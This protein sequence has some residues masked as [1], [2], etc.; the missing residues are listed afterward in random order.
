MVSGVAPGRGGHAAVADVEVDAVAAGLA[1]ADRDPHTPLEP[2]GHEQRQ[3]TMP[4]PPGEHPSGELERSSTTVAVSA[5]PTA[6]DVGERPATGA[7]PSSTSLK[8]DRLP[9]PRA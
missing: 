3:R 5:S 8:L 7:G 6:R 1:G 2:D 9:G 4:I